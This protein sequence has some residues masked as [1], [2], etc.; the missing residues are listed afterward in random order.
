[1]KG[2]I[3]M[4]SIGVAILS[5]LFGADTAQPQSFPSKPVTVIVP[6]PPGG[7]ADISMRII[8]HKLT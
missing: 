4:L 1:M 8:A 3:R 5:L 6:A 7:T 2:I